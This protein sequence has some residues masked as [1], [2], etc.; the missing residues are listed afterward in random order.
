MGCRLNAGLAVRTKPRSCILDLRSKT[1]RSWILDHGPKEQKNK[2]CIV[3]LK[4]KAVK[5]GEKQIHGSEPKVG[6]MLD[7]NQKLLCSTRSQYYQSLEER[8]AA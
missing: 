5:M 7:N 1:A 2:I 3:D 8:P 4:T 6:T